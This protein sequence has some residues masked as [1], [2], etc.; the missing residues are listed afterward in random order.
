MFQVVLYDWVGSKKISQIVLN[1][2]K[3][4]RK[5]NEC[6]DLEKFMSVFTY[7]DIQAK[8]YPEIIKNYIKGNARSNTIRDLSFFKITTYFY[9]RAKPN[10]KSEMIY[11]DLLAELKIKSKKFKKNDKEYIIKQLKEHKE[12]NTDMFDD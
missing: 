1:K 2:I 3:E 5:N 7:A 11:L 4:D 9:L 8:N 10:S 6:S 12:K